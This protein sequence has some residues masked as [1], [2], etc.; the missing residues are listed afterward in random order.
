MRDPRRVVTELRLVAST[1]FRNLRDDPAAFT[2]LVGRRFAPGLRGRLPQRGTG[3]P[4]AL[5][6]F[7]TDQ[8]AA[9]ATAL[10][11][12]RGG[13][14]AGDRLAARLAVLVGAPDAI[15]PRL[16]NDPRVRA[17]LDW[18]SGNLTEAVA[19]LDGSMSLVARRRRSELAL[20]QPLV[21]PPHEAQPRR[22]VETNE[23]SAGARATTR[24]LH[25]LTNSLPYTRSGYTSRTHSLL[26]AS[27]AAGIEVMAAT[28]L[29]YPA[30]IGKLGGPL[31]SMIDGVAY[32]RL[33]TASLPVDV[34]ER[35]A[36]QAAALDA[37]VVQFCPTI[38]HTTTDYTNALVSQDVA[39]RHGLPWVYEMRGQLEL[40]WVA[41]R[42]S[43]L[44]EAAER[45]ERVELL[46]AKEAE[47]ATAA[48]AVVV[49]SEVQADDL[50]SRG[51]PRARVHVV[52]N[53]VDPA[54]LKRSTAPAD[55]RTKL[56]L[57]T[58]GV[59][60]GTVSSLVGYEGLD[61]FLQALAI[62]RADGV[63][64]RGAIVGEGVSRPGLVALANELGIADAVVFPGRVPREEAI[65]WHEALDVFVV[66]R[67]DTPVCR[68]V[69]PMK[70]VE[71]MALG[72]PVVASDLP[73][74]REVAGSGA[75]RL[76][77][78][79]DPTD[80]AAALTALA[81]DAS[82]RA[83]LGARGRGLAREQTWDRGVMT[84]QELY[85]ALEDLRG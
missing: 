73:A 20:L 32:R 77:A 49:L 40:T 67:R 70:P 7:F 64:L 33:P 23:P 10:R 74:L 13:W 44:R 38:L 6:A 27:K 16:R 43:A 85:T 26:T 41:S 9:A 28:R 66:P 29:G 58:D 63:D 54:L 31:T 15:P 50:A 61:T 14:R 39:R 62:A 8:R 34:G 78:P 53:G 36:A 71:A 24:I 45:S 4:A 81:N 11:G 51:V 60:A 35:L 52:P 72:R 17:Q 69:T 83:E 48:D 30:T 5:G 47:L 42:P 57:P 65:A 56:G 18:E 55:G 46:R 3:L 80:W 75:G 2:L 59:W 22:R 84:Y 19:A 82:L 25:I 76:V 1:T 68:M 21:E 12:R 37:V 79:E